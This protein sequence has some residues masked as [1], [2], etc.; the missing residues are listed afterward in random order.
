MGEFKKIDTTA[1]RIK[2]A[3]EAAGKIQ[4]DLVR[5]TGIYKGT[6]SNYLKGKYSP[7]QEWIYKLAKAL[8]V[9]EMWL[10]G[11]DCPMYRTLDQKKNDALSD[12][13][14]EMRTD[15]D[16]LSIVEAIY[17]MDKEKRSNLLAFLK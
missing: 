16:F 2:I 1:N 5:E 8:D 7:K 12:I 17:K 6:L 4:A 3:M 10:W 14:V 15:D 13:I 11:Y 9:S